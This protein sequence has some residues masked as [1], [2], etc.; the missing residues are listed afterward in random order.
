MHRRPRRNTEYV[1]P[2]LL[3]ADIDSDTAAVWRPGGAWLAVASW[4]SRGGA[5]VGGCRSDQQ[6]GRLHPYTS[7]PATR[8]SLPQTKGFNLV[9]YTRSHR[10]WLATIRFKNERF[11]SGT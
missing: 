5:R 11:A 4:D 1:L 3:T 9:G 2:V 8:H 6:Q 7:T 10:K